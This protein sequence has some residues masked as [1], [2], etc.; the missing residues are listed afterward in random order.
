MK[1]CSKCGETKPLDGGFHKKKGGKFGRAARCKSCVKAYQSEW[2][3]RPEV[4]AHRAEYKAEHYRRNRDAILAQQA[5]HRARPEVRAHKAEYYAENRDA[6]LARMAEYHQANPH[7][8][9][10]K[11][12]LR[13]AKKYGHPAVIEPFTKDD[14]IARWGDACWHCGGPFEELDHAVIPVALGGHHT[15]ENCRPSCTPCNAKG[16]GIRRT[17]T[18]ETENTK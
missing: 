15:L 12:Y 2:Y 13:R 16:S 5:E 10:V 1:T 18:N 3:E 14:L 6:I 11:G 9:W 7:Q 17:N 4:K 8:Q